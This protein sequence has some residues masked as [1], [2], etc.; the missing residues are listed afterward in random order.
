MYAPALQVKIGFALCAL[1]LSLSV[2]AR[3]K[4]IEP[5][6]LTLAEAVRLA[7]ETHPRLDQ[8]HQRALTAQAQRDQAGAAL[9]PQIQ[10]A[11][12][13][14]SGSA[15]SNTSFQSGAIIQNR[16][17]DQ[18]TAGILLNQLIYD[19]G[20]SSYR[21]QAKAFSAEAR[22]FEIQADRAVTVFTVERAYFEAL[23][24]VQL[25]KIAEQTVKER[26]LIKDLVAALYQREKRSKLELSLVEVE[27]KNAQ[28]LHLQSRNDYKVAVQTL[29][30][31]I[32]LEGSGEFILEDPGRA[33]TAL[34]SL[35]QLVAEAV[36]HRPELE[37]MRRQVKS[38]VAALTSA[39]RQALPSINASVS[40]GESAI[41]DLNGRWWY[42]AF[43][44]ISVPLYTGGRIESEIREAQA[45]HN[46]TQARAREVAQEIE[47]Q[48]VAAY[49]PHETLKEKVGV[50]LE[51]AATARIAL[52]L[53]RER[54]RLGLGSIV[55]VTQAEVAF[56]SAE[57]AL[58]IAH[59]DV[60]TA[61]AALDYATGRNLDTHGTRE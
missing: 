4:D 10:S 5:S 58:A 51:Q 16:N 29:R 60:L 52:D 57:T 14:T 12:N 33:E 37:A 32:G 38:S 40:T 36:Q 18:A 20:R 47:L 49:H 56:T 44:S 59:Y 46:E 15:R 27:L 17:S 53:A 50:A 22:E 28:M 39:K 41:S 19:F 25:M 43:G 1:C 2:P 11:L 34:T 30:N 31:A 48:V 61:K 8:S 54:L 24:Q 35:D 26:S 6:T 42:G 9:L 7:L 21:I 23:K 3:A 55:E 45:L 13:S